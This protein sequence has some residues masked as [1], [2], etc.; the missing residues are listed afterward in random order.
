MLLQVPSDLQGLAPYLDQFLGL[1]GRERW[2]KRCD[3][4]D[5]DQRRSPFRWKIVAEYHWLE[6]G[7]GFQADVLAKEGH[8]LPELT[9][10]LILA[11]LNFAAS[12]VEIHA[13]LS[14]RGK[15]VLEGRLRDS[16]KAETGFAPLYL[17][18][19]LAQRLMDS[20]YEVE[21]ADM[22]GSARFDL[23]FSRH[24]FSGEVE[25]KSLS[26]DAGR[27]IHRKD[28]YR[29]M[30]AITSALA[31]HAEL[32]QQEVL[33]ISLDARLPSSTADQKQL[34]QATASL[35]RDGASGTARESGYRLERRP[36]AD[37]LGQAS[38]HDQKLFYQAC[39]VAFGENTHVAGSLTE[40][41]GCVVVMRSDRE[42]DPSKPKLEALRKAASQFT[43]ERPAFVAIQE[44]GIEPADL[45]L[46]HVRRKAAILSYALFGQYGGAHVNAT[47][48]TGFGAVVAREGRVGTP[49]FAI[50]N[51]KPKFPINAADAA[52]FLVHVSDA[53]FAAAIGAPLPAANISFL[54]IDPHD[55]ECAKPLL[56]AP[57]PK[58][59]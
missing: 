29:F 47:Y 48:V 18:I 3:Q 59:L 7:I 17:E 10:G 49:A 32:K 27:Q 15:R 45:M 24:S 6:M 23:L 4:L 46:P 42:D 38:L 1:I 26:A 50:P 39:G 31:S 54:P 35:L 14:Q 20:G 13:Q 11:A 19:D 34:V 9:D 51:P 58:L 5:A 21:F 37:Y 36:F 30:E 22:E 56:G 28:F 43:G 16:L 44:H 8:L 33:V 57:A 55:E 40:D 52:P 2:F 41:G 12:T 53:D 25:C